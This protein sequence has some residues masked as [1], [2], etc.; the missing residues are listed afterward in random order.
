M[1]REHVGVAD[2]AHVVGVLVGELLRRCVE[3]NR[4]DVQ[5]ELG[6]QL[7]IGAQEVVKIFHVYLCKSKCLHKNLIHQIFNFDNYVNLYFQL[8]Y[9]RLFY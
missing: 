9:F 2:E 4:R 1:Q 7:Q 5:H 3:L 6:R 8:T